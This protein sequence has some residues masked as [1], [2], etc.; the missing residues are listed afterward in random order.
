MKLSQ[1]VL[2]VPESITLKLNELAGRLKSE[3]KE[4]FNLTA[5]QLPF[6]PSEELVANIGECKNRLA[7]YQYSPAMG[8]KKLREKIIEH[9][10]VTRQIKGLPE[11]EDFD[12]ILSNG[13]KHSLFNAL[14][15]LVNPGDEV[16]LI[17]PYWLSYPEMAKFWNGKINVLQAKFEDSYLPRI[18]DLE[19]TITDKTRALIINSPNNPLGITYP[20]GWMEEFAKLLK[21]HPN[22]Y[23]LNDEIYFH[24]NYATDKPKYFYNYDPSLLRQTLIFDG[25]SKS[26]CATGLRL[27]YCIGPKEVVNAMG[28][29]QA[30]TTSG[31]NSLTQQSL[32]EYDFDK[33]Q[34]FL[35]PIKEH[36]RQNV[37]IMR[38]IFS[39]YNLDHLLYETTS[40]FYQL[41]DL[42]QTSVF[43]NYNENDSAG[44]ICAD[45]IEKAGVVTVPT[46]DFGLANA[47][48]MSLVL[49]QDE[50]KEAM[51]RVAKFLSNQ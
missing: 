42:S 44:A 19:K 35:V 5:G 41:V 20:D 33:T 46:S 49:K 21:K 28:K 30:Q 27:G 14:G 6:M 15:A 48:R 51:V 26:S 29:I 31:I 23:V 45:L 18:E 7:S 17:A 47:M 10:F 34:D 38:E 39:Q 8:L 12:A 22:L 3:G 25:I 11:V 36:L 50:L 40:A 9:V 37:A 13:G 4:I 43:A 1:R 24:L 16:L 2:D 32:L